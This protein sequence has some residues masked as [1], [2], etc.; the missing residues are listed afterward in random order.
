MKKHL[1]YL[2]ILMFLPG[3]LCAQAAGNVYY[4]QKRK[5]TYKEEAAYGGIAGYGNQSAYQQQAV[6]DTQYYYGQGADSVM[7]IRSSVL[8]NVQPDAYKM[9]LG[10]TQVGEN[11]QEVHDKITQRIDNVTQGLTSL[12]IPQDA[13]YIDF[14][15]Q[16]PIFGI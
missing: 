11:M 15:S 14:I 1:I 16:A 10:L 2:S 6:Y 9:I 3:I 4:N 7:T 5:A 8:I 13:I 12:G